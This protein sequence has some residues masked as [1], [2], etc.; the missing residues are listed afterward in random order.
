MTSTLMLDADLQDKIAQMQ[1][2]SE[3]IRMLSDSIA[4]ALR[5]RLSEDLSTDAHLLASFVAASAHSS[6]DIYR[7][8]DAIAGAPGPRPLAEPP[9]GADDER[10]ATYHL[11]HARQ[12]IHHSTR[13]IAHADTLHAW[14][15]R[16]M[17]MVCERALSQLSPENSEEPYTPERAKEA[18]DRLSVAS[19]RQGESTAGEAKRHLDAAREFARRAG[20]SVDHT[21]DHL[22]ARIVDLGGKT[23]SLFSTI[24]RHASARKTALIEKAERHLLAIT[25]ATAHAGV[26]LRESY[27]AHLADDALIPR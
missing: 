2:A 4:T 23:K 11:E 17:P 22:A 25:R 9:T 5:E 18:V 21:V 20:S 12:L 26:T 13:S 6:D 7:G 14:G 10:L 16:A 8:L 15:E 24:I 1:A 3:S 27:Q 19:A